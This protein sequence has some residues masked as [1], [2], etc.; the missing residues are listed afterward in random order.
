MTTRQYISATLLSGAMFMCG[1]GAHAA[2][3]ARR[4]AHHQS[5]AY[6]RRELH[7]Q[8]G[9]MHAPV[10][11]QCLHYLF[12]H[13]FHFIK[14]LSHNRKYLVCISLNQGAEELDFL[15]LLLDTLP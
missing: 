3:K 6:G 15:V 4:V 10:D 13:Y 11:V 8:F 14:K 9:E 2:Q 1:F 5:R 12:V 7:H